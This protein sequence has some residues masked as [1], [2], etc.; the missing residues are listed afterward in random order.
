MILVDDNYG[1]SGA[2]EEDPYNVEDCGLS[3]EDKEAVSRGWQVC[4][5]P[6]SHVHTRSSIAH[7]VATG[8]VVM[9]ACSAVVIGQHQGGRGG[10]GK[11]RRLAVSL[12]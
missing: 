4:S 7:C 3:Q 1:G 11:K 5:L 9:H 2:S 12:L 6:P 10:G 8:W